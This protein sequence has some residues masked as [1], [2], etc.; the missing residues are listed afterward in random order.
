M[1]EPDTKPIEHKHTVYA[2]GRL[3]LTDTERLVTALGAEPQ[4]YRHFLTQLFA[5]S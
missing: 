4:D 2:Q 3:I 5:N 1:F